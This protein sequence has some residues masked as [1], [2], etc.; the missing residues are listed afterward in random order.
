MQFPHGLGAKA[1]EFAPDDSE[2]VGRGIGREGQVMEFRKCLAELHMDDGK[3]RFGF[4]HDGEGGL[5]L[6]RGQI[7]GQGHGEQAAL[8]ATGIVVFL[9]H[10]SLTARGIVWGKAGKGLRCPKRGRPARN[11]LHPTA[12]RR[13]FSGKCLPRAVPAGQRNPKHYQA[14]QRLAEAV[15]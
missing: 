11:P 5:L 15:F 12:F 9:E 13:M 14:K 3:A 1:D 6:F 10:E 8:E 4:A 7:R 2:G